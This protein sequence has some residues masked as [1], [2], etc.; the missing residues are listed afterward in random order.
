[1]FRIHSQRAATSTADRD[2]APARSDH[3]DD[4]RA[5]LPA[6]YRCAD[7]QQTA[8]LWLAWTLTRR[9]HST[10]H[11]IAATHVSGATAH[12]L[13]E[14]AQAPPERL[15]AAS[16]QGR[17]PPPES[18]RDQ[19]GSRRMLLAAALLRNGYDLTDI[20]VITDVPVAMLQL[21]HEEQAAEDR[22]RTETSNLY[23]QHFRHNRRVIRV[24]AVIA[25]AAVANFLASLT[26]LLQRDAALG[27]VTGLVAT[28]LVLALYVIARPLARESRT[29]QPDAR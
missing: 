17:F 10:A 3:L 11:V 2:R 4:L 27:F 5:Q 26:A 21:L 7:D 25:V 15:F 28:T 13:A 23:R 12:R 6:E 1:M 29:R 24:L 22:R 20:A 18:D 9:G 8:Q 14:L 19:R 16:S